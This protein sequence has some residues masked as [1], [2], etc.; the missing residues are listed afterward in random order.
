MTLCYK[1]TSSN[2]TGAQLYVIKANELF[3]KEVADCFCGAKL[4]ENS[5]SKWTHFLPPLVTSR[6]SAVLLETIASAY[7]CIAYGYAVLSHIMCQKGP[8]VLQ[9]NAYRYFYEVVK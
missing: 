2:T 4:S 5:G 9:C 3:Y 8:L 7:E 6:M 1:R